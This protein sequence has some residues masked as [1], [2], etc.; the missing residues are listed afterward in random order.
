MEMNLEQF[1]P[2]LAE[3]NRL[4]EESRSVTITDYE[5]P[6]QLEIVHKQRITLKSVRVAI[7]KK[8]KEL[9][10]EALTFQKAVIA[11]EKEL[12]EIIQPEEDRL[13]AL[14]EQAKLEA[15]K[16]ERARK[17]PERLERLKEIEFD[18]GTSDVYVLQQMSDV[19][20]ES[21]MN[22]AKAK[23]EA[24]KLARQRTEQ[25]AKEAELKRKE[26]ELEAKEK[27]LKKEEEDRKRAEHEKAE[28]EAREKRRA[29]EL[30]QAR[31]E[32]ERK[33]K[34]DAERKAAE[35]KARIEREEKERK[36]AEAKAERSRRF[37]AWLAEQGYTEETE[38]DYL[39]QH[40][41][42]HAI[43]YKRVGTYAK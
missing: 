22:N 17:W 42:T 24:E 1:N 7:T 36:D 15:I 4:A 40:T 31:L 3:L 29:E 11:K 38:G 19:D 14:E 23:I 20:F 5:D 10:E 28:A 2:T 35:E 34:E 30:E 12:I 21:F 26:E 27:A 39:I 33:A 13:D 8:G 16:R 18:P 43:L 37:K 25:L 6:K 9:R 32:G 41:E